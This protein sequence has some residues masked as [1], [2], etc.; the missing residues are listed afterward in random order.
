MKQMG[1][2]QRIY[3]EG[4][5]IETDGLAWV[6]EFPKLTEFSCE[7]YL[8]DELDLTP[9]AGLTELTRL[10]FYQNNNTGAP[11]SDL[12]PLAGLTKMKRLDLCIDFDVKDLAPLS[13][14]TQ[15]EELQLYG[16]SN[17]NNNSGLTDLSA[18]S[19]MTRLTSLRMAVFTTVAFPADLLRGENPMN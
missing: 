14:M 12:S 17:N 19:G 7:G 9:F 3:L 6:A 2:L 1:N 8:T 15:L 13:G 18:L 4:V 16:T 10:S 11:V 5:S